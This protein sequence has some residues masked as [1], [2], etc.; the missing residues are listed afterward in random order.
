MSLENWSWFTKLSEEGSVTK[1]AQS[2]EISQQALSARL[3]ALEKDIGAKLVL[4]GTPLSLTPAGQAFLLYAREQ[5]DAQQSLMREIGEVT[6]GGAGVLKVGVPQM[7]GRIL[8]PKVI[9]RV[10]KELPDVSFELTEETNRELIRKVER[11]EVDLVVAL[12]GASHPGV[13]VT[14]LVE[15]EVVLAVHQQLLKDV[16]GLDPEPALKLVEEKGLSVLRECPF[17]LGTVDDISGR[18]AY[19]ELRNAAI[20]QK[21]VVM[22]EYTSTLLQVC[23]EGIAAVFA[24]SNMIDGTVK[25][26]SMLV[27]IPLGEQARYTIS[28]G[29]PMQAPEWRAVEVLKAALVET[30]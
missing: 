18:I 10:R 22:S 4:R 11:G 17:G 28:M 21:P 23:V 14:P 5:Q 25:D 16:T 13:T 3:A 6:G 1:A 9:A 2:L 29:T 15:E 24:P 26:S 30:V 8:M 19:S 7:R 27:R 20:R 12:F